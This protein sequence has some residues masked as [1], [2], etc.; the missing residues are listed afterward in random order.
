[1]RWAVRV[2]FG[3]YNDLEDN[4]GLVTANYPFNSLLTAAAPLLSFVPVP[5]GSAPLP[6]CNAQLQA[7]A[8]PCSIYAPS[9]LEPTMHTPTVQQWSFTV[10]RAME[11]AVSGGGIQY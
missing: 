11:C 9:G 3:I 2:G 1:G 8:Q 10:E 6:P 4:P 7:A 5:S